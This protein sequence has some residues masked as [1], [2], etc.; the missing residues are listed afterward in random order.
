MAP[1]YKL[2][3]FDARGRGEPTRLIFAAAGVEFEDKRLTFEEWPAIKP[4][5]PM[6][7]LPLLEVDGVTLCQSL[8]IA[9]FAARDVGLA[10]K[11]NLEQAQADMFVDEIS[12][13]LPKMAGLFFEKDEAAK[14]EKQKEVE[15]LIVKTYTILE[16]LSGSAGYLVGNRLLWCDLIFFNIASN[17]ENLKPGTVQNYPKLAKSYENVKL[18][19]RIAAYLAKRKETPF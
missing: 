13:L 7:G 1:K 2:T 6:G 12:E 18:N 4:T 5:T 8:A 16:K 19:S 3:Y 11:S 14:A 15:E 17:V 10:G 9:R